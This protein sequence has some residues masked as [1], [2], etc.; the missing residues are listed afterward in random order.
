MSDA[1][2]PRPGLGRD[3]YGSPY[4]GKADITSQTQ[5]SLFLVTDYQGASMMFGDEFE[6]WLS[7]E[8]EHILETAQGLPIV[9]Q[10]G[11]LGTFGDVQI[12]ALLPGEMSWRKLVVKVTYPK[13]AGSTTKIEKAVLRVETS[14]V[15]RGHVTHYQGGPAVEATV[16]GFWIDQ[17]NQQRLEARS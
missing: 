13:V 12:M 14:R 11:P 16:E 17:L 8:F 2:H 3:M 9:G 4:H 1:R 10:V 5:V 15:G 7:D 6:I